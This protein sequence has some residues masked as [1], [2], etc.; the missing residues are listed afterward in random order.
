MHFEDGTFSFAARAEIPL[1]IR[2]VQQKCGA[3]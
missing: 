2:R 3:K 1:E